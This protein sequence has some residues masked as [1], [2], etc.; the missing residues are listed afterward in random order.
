MLKGIDA[1]FFCKIDQSEKALIPL[2]LA[3]KIAEPISEMGEFYLMDSSSSFNH[4]L[5]YV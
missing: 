4:G 5:V 2:V 1:E 3:K